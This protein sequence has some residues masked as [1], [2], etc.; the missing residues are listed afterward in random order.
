[1]GI[2]R[3]L[4]RRFLD[5][6]PTCFIGIDAPD[7]NLDLE[8]R[9]KE[10]GIPVVHYVSPT[11]WAWRSE[12]IHKI[13]RAVHAMLVLF[14]FEERLYRE[15]GIPV[16]YV[17]HPLAD[18][19]AHHP[20]RQ[21][22]RVE[23]RVPPEAPVI[24]L[25][26][27]SRVSELEQMA[28]LFIATAREIVSAIPDA[29]FLAPAANRATR[30]LVEAALQRA[31]GE[32]RNL[33]ILSGHAHDAMAA[34][35]V[36]LVASGTATLEAALL[37][38]PMVVAYRMPRISWWIMSARRRVRHISLPNILAGEAL[39]PELLQDDATPTNLARAVVGLLRDPVARARLES[40]FSALL[41][42][43]KQD[44]STKIAEALRPFLVQAEP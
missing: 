44:T 15:A 8:V 26:P 39:V 22:V 4:A 1:V 29:M 31:G 6:P 24:A 20:G 21:A 42:E 18:I 14:P 23:L 3:S 40:R 25:L 2:R 43:L 27:G 34:A 36:V 12:R 35:D 9:L 30:D 5:S 10:S 16:T 32:P 11:I 38:R 28:D 37:G 17:G 41:A 33:T 13:R 7:F 19:L